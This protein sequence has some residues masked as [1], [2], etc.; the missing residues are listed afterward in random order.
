VFGGPEFLLIFGERQTK[1]MLQARGAL[2]F[3][4]SKRRWAA[5][6][7]ESQ[8]I[9]FWEEIGAMIAVNHQT[10]VH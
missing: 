9:D 1:R 2:W 6:A 5:R 4:S 7:R 3:E 8:G 10:R